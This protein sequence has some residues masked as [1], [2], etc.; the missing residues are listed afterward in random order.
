MNIH[1]QKIELLGRLIK[2]NK[3]TL[4][5]ALLL[6]KESNEQSEILP[7][8]VPTSNY[9]HTSHLTNWALRFNEDIN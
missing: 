6:L 8:S 4:D 7:I 5:E 3:V 9:W 1:E 2:E